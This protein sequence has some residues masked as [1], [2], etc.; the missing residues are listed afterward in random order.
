MR[1]V[2]IFLG[3]MLASDPAL[4]QTLDA[5]FPIPSVYPEEAGC[6]IHYVAGLDP[7]GDGFL[8]V[9]T[10]PG[11]GHRK[12]DEVHNGDVV[13]TCVRSGAWRGIVYTGSSQQ[14]EHRPQHDTLRGWVHSNWLINGAG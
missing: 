12:I 1:S 7:A 10:G 2:F 9:R 8:A 6:G 4:S 5:P 11:T 14:N 3:A 13:Y